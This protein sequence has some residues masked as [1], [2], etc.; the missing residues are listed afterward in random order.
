MIVVTFTHL[1]F[2]DMGGNN[3]N[4]ATLYLCNLRS[5]LESFGA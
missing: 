4:L 1:S 5:Y 2:S 3:N